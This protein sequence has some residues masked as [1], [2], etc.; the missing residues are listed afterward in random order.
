MAIT[1]LA[2]LFIVVGTLLSVVLFIIGII[3]GLSKKGWRLVGIS[4][5]LFISTLVVYS[6]AQNFYIQ[7]VRSPVLENL[8]ENSI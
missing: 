7:K 8:Q 2:M 6:I 1:L 5:L 3:R 4:V